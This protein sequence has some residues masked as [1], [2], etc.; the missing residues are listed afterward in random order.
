MKALASTRIRV[1]PMPCLEILPAE[2]AR[3]IGREG[4]GRPTQLEKLVLSS[5]MREVDQPE[6]RKTGYLDR[7]YGILQAR[8]RGLVLLRLTEEERR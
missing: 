2:V 4:V 3:A 5:V 6:D 1:T 8:M 7:V